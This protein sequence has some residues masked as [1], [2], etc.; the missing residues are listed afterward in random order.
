MPCHR[1]CVPPSSSPPSFTSPQSLILIY[2]SDNSQRKRR[3]NTQPH[4]RPPRSLHLLIRNHA[5]HIPHQVPD[6]I[7]AMV[8]KRERQRQLREHLERGGPRGK[9]SRHAGALEVPSG[10]G[11]DQVRGAEDVEEPAQRGPGDAVQRAAVPCDLWL[12]DAEVG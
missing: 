11:C 4:N 10:E 3:H 5:T 2:L 7:E 12:V 9:R 1:A 6:A 8:R